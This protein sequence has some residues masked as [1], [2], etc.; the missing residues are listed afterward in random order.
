MEGSRSVHQ[1]SKKRKKATARDDHD[2]KNKLKR[3]RIGKKAKKATTARKEKAYN[4]LESA[5]ALLRANW[6]GFS[7]AYGGV[8]LPPS[9][10]GQRRIVPRFSR[11]ASL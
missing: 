10:G 4:R 8:A 2:G 7:R 11:A 9:F 5:L 1:A 6:I 3:P